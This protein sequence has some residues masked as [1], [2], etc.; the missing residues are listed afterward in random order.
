MKQLL[1][2]LWHDEQG[3]LNFLL[4]AIGAAAGFLKKPRVQEIAGASAPILGGLAGGRAEGRQAETANLQ[5]Q[6]RLEALIQNQIAQQRLQ[7]AGLGA[8]RAQFERDSPD[9]RFQQALRGNLAANVQDVGVQLPEHLKPYQIQFTGGL[10][11]SALGAGGRNVGQQLAQL[12]A[13]RL[14]RDTFETPNLPGA[15]TVPRLPQANFLDKLLG[16]AGP[17]TGLIGAVGAIGG[18]QPQPT[19]GSIID[20]DL[21]RPRLGPYDVEPPEPDLKDFRNPNLLFG[22]RMG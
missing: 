1:Y 8:Q 19:Q 6:T 14:G 15:P 17:V 5:D 2:R 7:H 18:R 10:R 22:P 12:A 21:L 11:P 16:V 20:P 4:P 3:I 13:S 9:V